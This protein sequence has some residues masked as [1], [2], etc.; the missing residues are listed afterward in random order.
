[1]KS[2]TRKQVEAEIIR[3]MAEAQDAGL[4][5]GIEAAR[6]AFPGVPDVVLYECW[7]N[8]D[9]QRTEAW[10]QTIERTIDVEV[11]RS[12]LQATGQTPT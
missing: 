8:L 7:T 6:R 1:M 2:N 9:T 5:D 4:G 12:A 10:W 11:I 3:T